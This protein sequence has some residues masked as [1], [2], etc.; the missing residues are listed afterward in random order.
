MA[1][2]EHLNDPIHDLFPAANRAD[3]IVAIRISRALFEDMA[4]NAGYP[5]ET[6]VLW[7]E[8]DEEGF[9]TP[10]IFYLHSEDEAQHRRWQIDWISVLALVLLL[11]TVWLLLTR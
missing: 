5:A 9:Y 8:P 4:A 1:A 7:G 3:D 2:T 6:D 11:I 10:S